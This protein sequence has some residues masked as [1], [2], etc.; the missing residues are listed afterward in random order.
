MDSADSSA[1]GPSELGNKQYWEKVYERDNINF[2]ENGDIGEIWFGES[3]AKKIVNWICS[4]VK[5]YSVPILDLGCGNGHILLSLASNGYTNL[6][7]TDYAPNAIELA[8][9]ICTKQNFDIDYHIFDLLSDEDENIFNGQLFDIVIDKGT[10]DA[11]SLNAGVIEM[12]KSGVD[13][14]VRK[15][16]KFCKDGAYFIITSCNWTKDELIDKFKE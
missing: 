1:F 5:D 11:I 14:Y 8:R 4:R 2:K 3:S 13:P 16:R 15:V 10:Y 12:R 7:G 6:T 9:E